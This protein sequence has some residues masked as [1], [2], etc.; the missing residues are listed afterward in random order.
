MI[1]VFG[2]ATSDIVIIEEQ[3]T[4]LKQAPIY[5]F[6]KATMNGYKLL[7]KDCINLHIYKL[8]G[9]SRKEYSLGEN[10][11][12][13]LENCERVFI[14]ET[15]GENFDHL[16]KMI[17]CEAIHLHRTISDKSFDNAIIMQY[18]NNIMVYDTKG[19]DN[20]THL[21]S[22]EYCNDLRIFKMYD[23]T[24][25]ESSRAYFL[26]TEN[27]I[28]L[29]LRH[30]DSTIAAAHIGYN[31]ST[32][33]RDIHSQV[34]SVHEKMFERVVNQNRFLHKGKERSV[35]KKVIKPHLIRKI[36]QLD[37]IIEKNI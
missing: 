29:C 10:I 2:S 18:C 12:L 31:C 35:G 32:Y 22:A 9:I 16:I 17:G 15:Y 19:V 36:K 21:L 4:S 24:A 7:V 37:Q 5:D 30:L 8:S 27:C 11:L 13:E 14:H 20:N 26:K 25:S 3:Q 23:K 34:F 6:S 1:R 33:L 28:D